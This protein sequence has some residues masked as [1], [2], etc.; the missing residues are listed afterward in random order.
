M[1]NDSVVVTDGAS[2]RGGTLY[3]TV[4]SSAPGPAS[5]VDIRFS[6]PLLRWRFF[7]CLKAG[8][9]RRTPARLAAEQPDHPICTV[10]N[11]AFVV[12]GAIAFYLLFLT[13]FLLYS[14]VL[15]P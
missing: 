15:A 10:A 13:G 14:S 4:V 2:S 3:D 12:G 11:M 8:P 1:A 7:L 6:L 5:P 9:E